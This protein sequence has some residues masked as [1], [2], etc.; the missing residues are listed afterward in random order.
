MAPPQTAG[1]GEEMVAE[2]ARPGSMDRMPAGR[3]PFNWVQLLLGVASR[4]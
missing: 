2:Q 4:Y 3:M 1:K